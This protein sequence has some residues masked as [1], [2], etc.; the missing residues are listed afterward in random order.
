MNTT[1]KTFKLPTILF[2][3]AVI[4]LLATIPAS[5][6]S[7]PPMAI[8][9]LQIPLSVGFITYGLGL[10]GIIILEGLIL[11]KRENI[12]F[13][14]GISLSFLANFCSLILGNLFIWGLSALPYAAIGWQML[15]LSYLLL[16]IFSSLLFPLKQSKHFIINPFFLKILSLFSWSLIWFCGFIYSMVLLS[17]PFFSPTSFFI[18]ILQ[19][20]AVAIFMG[21]GF[22]M[23]LVSEGFCLK[24][25]LPENS[26]NLGKT[27]LIMNV[28]SYAY[29]AIPITLLFMMF[30][31]LRPQYFR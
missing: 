10:I 24:K 9:L 23:S 7:W 8:W 22:A 19:L 6:N 1:A 11:A 13:N 21:I 26:G 5:A 3:G 27:I 18:K 31:F 14:K 17:L 16:V 25:L 28:R 20:L 29:I 15:G 2:L 12:S 30:E 4:W